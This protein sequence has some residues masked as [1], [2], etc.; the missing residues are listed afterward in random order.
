MSALQRKIADA[1]LRRSKEEEEEEAYRRRNYPW[2]PG[3]FK[4]AS[5]GYRDGTFK[6]PPPI[7][8]PVLLTANGPI[9]SASDL[10][11]LAEMESPPEAIET[12]QV[13]IH[14]QEI[15][16]VTI[17]HV[18]HDERQRMEEKAD[19]AHG[20]EEHLTV[21]F[22]GG[23]RFACTVKALKAQPTL[24]DEVEEDSGSGKAGEEVTASSELAEPKSGLDGE[25]EN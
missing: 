20:I 6:G 22:E 19:V 9:S 1:A 8:H 24:G 15:R 3:S 23:R 10:Q 18:S 11:K 7:R 2:P 12:I 21:M 14:G 17:C 25:S 16:K 13:D 4:K 5:D